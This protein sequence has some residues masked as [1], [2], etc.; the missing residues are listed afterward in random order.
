MTAVALLVRLQAKPGRGADLATFLE[1]A[2][3]LVRDEPHTTS[4]FAT[5]L[6]DDQYAIFDSFANES[7]RQEHLDGKVAAA[8]MARADELLASPPSIEPCTVLAQKLPVV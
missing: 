4:W 6:G 1:E 2:L 5:R 7:G 3:P 8:L